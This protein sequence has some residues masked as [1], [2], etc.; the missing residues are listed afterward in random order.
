MYEQHLLTNL[1]TVINIM[2][3]RTSN[4]LRQ[5]E[6]IHHYQKKKSQLNCFISENKKD[7]SKR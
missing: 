2:A 6:T 1:A 5:N 3:T 4:F 7:T